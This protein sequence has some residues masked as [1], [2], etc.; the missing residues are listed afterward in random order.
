MVAIVAIALALGI[1]AILV[2]PHRYTGEAYIRGEF[3]AAPDT[4]AK[5]NATMTSGSLNL[6]LVRVIETQSQLLQSHLLAR[7]VV[8]QLGLQ[9][10]RPLV[11]SAAKASEDEMDIAAT[12]L[13]PGLSVTSD[14]RSY[15]IT[16]RFTAADPEL[17][18]LVTNAFV[19]ELLRSAK[20]QTLFRQRSLAQDT[21]SI[22][23]AK[24]GDKHPAVAR[25]RM[26]LAATDELVKEQLNEGQEAILQAAGE[27]VT[28]A[29]SSPSSR[30]AWIA[31]FL[32]GGL[33]MSVGAALWL[34]RGRWLIYSGYLA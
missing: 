5:D 14:P 18:E 34:E 12:R 7:R 30:K 28:R 4:V 33:A 1:I 16:V 17:A 8:Q 23:L 25:A 19:V 3:F 2:M 31:L 6:D 22:Q 9:R 29:I 32:L 13:L 11:S 15:L 26:Q 20:L 24:F 27:A 10:L 21:L